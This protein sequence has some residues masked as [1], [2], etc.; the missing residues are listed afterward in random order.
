MVRPSKVSNFQDFYVGAIDNHT[1]AWKGT[2]G[3]RN[4]SYILDERKLMSKYIDY[5]DYKELAYVKYKKRHGS[6]KYKQEMIREA[7]KSGITFCLIRFR[8]HTIVGKIEKNDIIMF[9]TYH[10]NWSG[11]RL[12]DRNERVNY[13]YWYC[14]D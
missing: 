14:K 8:R 1:Y 12:S 7:C 6:K 2:I 10:N 9:D 13:I 5:K 11:K 3:S 4:F